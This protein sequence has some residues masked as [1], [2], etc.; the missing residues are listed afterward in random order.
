MHFD[1]VSGALSAGVAQ[2][3]RVVGEG[4]RVENDGDPP[5]SSLVHPMNELG[6]VVGLADFDLEPEGRT[7]GGADGDEISEGGAAVYVRLA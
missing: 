4:R 3:V 1:E 7:L 6:L 2:G 5:V